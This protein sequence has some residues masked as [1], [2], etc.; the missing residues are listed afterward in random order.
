MSRIQPS[1]Q[2]R[3]HTLDVGSP[4]RRRQRS[5]GQSLVEFAVV[6]P[7]FLL[8]LAA[9][10]DFGLG[11]YSQMTV[12]NAAREGARLGV[13]SQPFSST[14]VNDRVVAMTAGLDQSNLTVSITCKHDD[15]SSVSCSST[16][17]GDEIQVQVDYDYHMLW[18]LAFG[19]TIDLS[20]TVQM[21]IE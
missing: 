8:I 6:L 15:G 10:I 17:T 13:V 3:R 5:R 21:R 11:L 2:D 9:V 7:I 1:R 4:H 14:A 16:T 19:N 12:I 20:S 18:P